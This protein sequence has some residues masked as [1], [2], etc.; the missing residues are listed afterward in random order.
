MKKLLASAL[1]SLCG[2]FA[3]QAQATV[4]DFEDLAGRPLFASLPSNY[5]GISWAG[6]FW[7]YSVA[8]PPYNAHSGIVRI[9]SNGSNSGDSSFTFASP[10]TFDGAW[11][12]GSTGVSFSLYDAGV[13]VH[14]TGTL[15]ANGT[16]SFLGTGYSG[17]VD[18]VVVNGANGYYAL[19]DLQFNA[20]SNAVPEPAT[21]ALLSLG[22]LGFGMSR[23][24][25]S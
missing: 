13:L 24:R 2:L 1:F 14:T 18:R 9:G 17:L 6:N 11:F 3:V 12:A 25:K 19:D 7:A 23:R 16:P 4:L 10:V 8:Q 21:L 15:N 22:L 5:A 20:V